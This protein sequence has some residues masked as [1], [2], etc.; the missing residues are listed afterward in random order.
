MPTATDIVPVLPLLYDRM[1]EAAITDTAKL[2]HQVEAQPLLRI[3]VLTEGRQALVAANST[4]GLAL[5]D[6]EIDYVLNAYSDRDPTDVELMMFSVVNS[7][8]CRHKIFS[9]FSSQSIELFQGF[10]IEI[11]QIRN[12]VYDAD[13][14]QLID[15][16][17]S[18]P[19]DIH[20]PPRRK[21]LD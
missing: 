20:S 11:K 16:L 7:E 14:D 21:M 6:E 10:G 1:T 2:F 19:F 4:M 18:Q 15:N 13:V 12:V 17:A 3:P 5:S 9:G 8:H